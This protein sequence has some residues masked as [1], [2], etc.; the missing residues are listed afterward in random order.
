MDGAAAAADRG[1]PV[2]EGIRVTAR[3]DD[4]SDD[5]LLGRF[6]GGEAAAFAV[7]LSRYQAP[8]FNF[9]ARTVRDTD[10][11]ADLLQEVFTRVIQ[12]S[13]DF[14]RASKFSTWLY[15]IARNMCID[16]ARRMTHRRHASLDASGPNGRTASDGGTA[17][18]WV[19]RVALEQPDVD[20]SAAAGRLRGRIAQAIESLPAE[21]REV[22]LMR[23]L[24]QLP[25]AEIAVVVGVSENTVKSRMRYALERLQEALA[26]Y[27][28]YARAEA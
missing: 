10:A 3:L 18:P 7:L 23:Q 22:F 16:H 14:N 11:A 13:A 26:D 1:E 8:V 9:I 6:A 27:E 15:A 5:E 21:Q 2:G 12:H 24:Q 17:A 28:E 20:S 19:E 25:F 4:M